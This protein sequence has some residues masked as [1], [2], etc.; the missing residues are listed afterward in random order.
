MDAPLTTPR[1]RMRPFT[2]DDVDAL[3]AVFSHPDVTAW[4]G[5]PTRE[6]AAETIAEHVA[7]Q[8]AHGFGQWAAED[9]ATGALVGEVGIQLLEGGPDVEIGWV[10]ARD[11]WGEGLATEAALPWLEVA[12]DELGLD[13]VLAVIRPENAASRRVAEKL[14]MREAGTRH[15]YG[16]E[17][18]LYALSRPRPAAA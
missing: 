6:Q 10:I 8:A 2:E 5:V 16:R 18:A 14:G 17:M 15:A 1:L 7:H 3:H 12:W 9:R 11:R 13:E 4:I